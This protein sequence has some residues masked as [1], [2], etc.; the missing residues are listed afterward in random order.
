M[1]SGPAVRTR[2][3][4]TYYDTADRA[5][6]R[7]GIVLRVRKEGRR[8]IQTVK[9]PGA[10]NGSILG[11]GEWEDKIAGPHPDPQAPHTG[12]FFAE[13]ADRLL[14]VFSTEVT[15]SSYTLSPDLHTR[16]EAA[17]DRGKI[18]AAGR[19]RAEPISEI[20]L[21]LKA[22]SATA[23]FDAALKLL[24]VAPLRVEPR[25]KAE[26]G[27][28]LAAGEQR[29]PQAVH[30]APLDIDWETSGEDVLRRAGRACVAQLLGNEAAAV[31]GQPEGVHQMRVAVR[32]FRAILSAFGKLVPVECRRSLDAELRWLARALGA[33]RNFDVFAGDLL[34][35]A[36]AVAVEAPALERLRKA[37]ERRRRQAYLAARRAIQSKRFTILLLRLMRWLDGNGWR[38][39]RD[40][41]AAGRL[42]E[43]IGTIAPV[44]LD[45]RRRAVH[46][47]SRGFA[48]QSPQQRHKLRIALKKLRYTTELFGSLYPSPETDRFTRWLK[49]LQ[50]ELGQANDIEV[51]REIVE[52]LLP[53]RSAPAVERVGR[54]ILAW[55]ER[56]LAAA[57]PRLRDHVRRLD[58]AKPF[59]RSREEDEAAAG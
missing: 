50:D 29:V 8:F 24:D 18:H 34:A 2:L 30:A 20:E 31:A 32:R 4:A 10:S 17:V 56:R 19:D 59:W 1:A 58:R 54:R 42:R 49:R 26:R 43:P 36:R 22:G 38:N 57:E 45:R 23:L 48:D 55:H 25:S 47:R 14:P 27:Y 28:H 51:G 35:P 33:A 6:S 11:R 46:K 13:I 53:A 41:A 16:I 37:A 9:S 15:R 3:A 40:S 7:H 5:L 21:E 39:D 44:L 52:I 12:R